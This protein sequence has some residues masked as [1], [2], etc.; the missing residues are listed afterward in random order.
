[1]PGARYSPRLPGAGGRTCLRSRWAIAR[2]PEPCASATTP[3]A[4][5][6]RR[7]A[8]LAGG[9][10]HGSPVDPPADLG[11]RH[12]QRLQLGGCSAA[13]RAPP[14]EP[15]NRHLGH[16]AT[17][18]L[19]LEAVGELAQ[20]RRILGTMDEQLGNGLEVD[21]CLTW[22]VR[23]SLGRLRTALTRSSTRLVAS[24]MSVP[25]GNSRMIRLTLRAEVE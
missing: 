15:V 23:A 25:S 22:G 20:F 14:P 21:Q 4:P 24:P 19:L 1:M 12:L 9:Q 18:Q 6:L 13:R 10:V 17:Q 16:A 2:N 11:Q 8:D 7:Y 5:A 3:A